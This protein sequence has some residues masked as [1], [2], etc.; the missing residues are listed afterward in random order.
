MGAHKTKPALRCI[1]MFIVKDL[2][3]DSKNKG[4]S[5][6]VMFYRIVFSKGAGWSGMG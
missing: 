2:V 6:R 3:K 4:K 5:T 1:N